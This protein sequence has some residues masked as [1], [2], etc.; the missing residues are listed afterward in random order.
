L[1]ISNH[2]GKTHKLKEKHN[3]K[4]NVGIQ[5][6]KLWFNEGKQRRQIQ[7]KFRAWVA[8]EEKI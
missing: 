4:G 2:G 3:K 1:C 7:I 8:R 5:V 6:E